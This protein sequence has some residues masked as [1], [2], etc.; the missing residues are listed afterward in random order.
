MRTNITMIKYFIGLCALLVSIPCL[1]EQTI[2]IDDVHNTLKRSS[3][4]KVITYTIGPSDT[5]TVSWLQY[6]KFNYSDAPKIDAIGLLINKKAYTLN[7]D[8][9]KK[10]YVIKAKDLALNEKSAKINKF[11]SGDFIE[12]L[13]G[14][15]DYEFSKN[16][17]PIDA[18]WIGEIEVK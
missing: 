7:V 9:S 16:N 18:Y 4:S 10:E 14:S 17:P 5:F 12:L 8:G 1:S 13:V 15:F 3:G 6:E 11:N 2:I